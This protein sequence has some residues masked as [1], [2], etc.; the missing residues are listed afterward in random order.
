[1]FPL[2]N[3]K[4]DLKALSDKKRAEDC[5]RF[6]KTGSGQY[7][8]GDVFLGITTPDLKM[9]AKAHKDLSIIDLQDLITNKYHE[10]RSV[11]L[12]ILVD[13]YFKSSEKDKKSTIDFYLHNRKFINN[14]DLVDVS[15][16]ILGDYLLN[17][18]KSVLFKLV[19]SKSIWDRRIAIVSTL[20]FIKNDKFATTLKLSEILLTDNHDLIHKAV[21]WMLREVGK[22]DVDVLKNFLDEHASV[23]PRT[24]LRYSIEK[25]DERTRKHYMTLPSK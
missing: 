8:E 6:F 24:M 21:G 20:V 25:F 18:D 14:W 17:K 5:Q 7:G 3:I 16:K 2:T 4:N 9:V 15:C 1:M 12:M 23:M 13:R 10:F 19:E 22:R 11:A